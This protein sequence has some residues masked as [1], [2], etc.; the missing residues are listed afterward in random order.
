M[1]QPIHNQYHNILILQLLCLFFYDFCW[2]GLSNP[3]HATS[4]LDNL[5]RK[6]T[7]DRHA[8]LEQTTATQYDNY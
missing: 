1:S 6:T 7:N 3:A 4:S 8:Q 5:R 2:S